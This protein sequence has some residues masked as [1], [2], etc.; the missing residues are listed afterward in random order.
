MPPNYRYFK[1]EEIIGL[2][3]DLCAMLDLARGRAGVPFRIL[4]GLRTEEQ[5]KRVGGA[6]NSTHLRGLAADLF[7]DDRIRYSVVKALIYIGFRRIEVS[8][9]NHIHC[10][11]GLAPEY[12]QN[13]FGIE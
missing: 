1:P 2:H 13:W 9:D 10:D 4:S 11:I 7:A 6:I 5:N 3:P 8:K 12:P